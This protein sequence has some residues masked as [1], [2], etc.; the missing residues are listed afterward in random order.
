MNARRKLL[1]IPENARY[2]SV[3]LEGDKPQHGA[4]HFRFPSWA[5]ASILQEVALNCP[6]QNEGEDWL[7]W[8]RRITPWMGAIIGRCWWHRGFVL[9]VAE[10]GWRADLDEM[11]NYGHEV[12]D[13]LQEQGYSLG[14]VLLLYNACTDALRK[15]LSI[16]GQ[17]HERADFSDSGE[18]GDP[19]DQ[20]SPPPTQQPSESE[21]VAS[22]T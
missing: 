6:T 8:A 16:I 19:T 13:E 17:A 11:L 2:W 20:S 22:T 12:I 7:R 4:H 5:M 21:K 1:T 18:G 15:R 3:T 10:P 9:A 14:E